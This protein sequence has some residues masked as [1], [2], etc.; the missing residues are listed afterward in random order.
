MLFMVHLWVTNLT[1]CR[2]ASPGPVALAADNI[3]DNAQGMLSL[4]WTNECG[5]IKL[6]IIVV[7]R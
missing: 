7:K 6:C 5:V 2:M 3:H 1:E 4:T